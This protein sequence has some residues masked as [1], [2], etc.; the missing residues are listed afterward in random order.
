[1]SIMMGGHKQM[2]NK[3]KRLTDPQL[4]EYIKKWRDKKEIAE[5]TQDFEAMT[6]AQINL[7]I[8]IKEDVR[9]ARHR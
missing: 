9:R 8:G 7:R 4:D 6:K 2:S 3:I 1:M 5:K